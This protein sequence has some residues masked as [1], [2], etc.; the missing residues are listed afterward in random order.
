MKLT[1]VLRPLFVAIVLIPFI[2]QS[3][4]DV[5]SLEREVSRLRRDVR[6]A[7]IRYGRDAALTRMWRQDLEG[8]EERLR[9]AREREESRSAR[10]EVDEILQRAQ[11]MPLRE[12]I[13][14]LR[15]Q[16]YQSYGLPTEQRNRI[17]DLHN[18]LI[19]NH[20][21][22]AERLRE[23]FENN[24][25]RYGREDRRTKNART[26]YHNYFDSYEGRE[27]NTTENRV[28]RSEGRMSLE[29]ESTH[30]SQMEVLERFQYDH[31]NF[32]IHRNFEDSLNL[33]SNAMYFKTE[34]PRAFLHFANQ[35]EERENQGQAILILE[36][37]LKR[38]R[39]SEIPVNNEIRNLQ[40]DL[41]KK[42]MELYLLEERFEDYSNLAELAISREIEHPLSLEELFERSLEEIN[43]KGGFSSE[44]GKTNQIEKLSVHDDQRNL[45]KDVQRGY[46]FSDTPVSGASA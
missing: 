28:R 39:N 43:Q 23:N 12:R 6:D 1:S 33:L 35:A 15:N 40:D 38:F 18:N 11:G 13:Q 17:T 2:S 25:S 14:F 7:E 3:F 36:E 19:E 22:T 4:A 20:N 45:S 41:I 37:G 29:E 24:R 21:R 10:T 31:P 9:A 27:R 42:L 32:S 44:S 16:S 34:A 46:I 5:R 30:V 8:A 26:E